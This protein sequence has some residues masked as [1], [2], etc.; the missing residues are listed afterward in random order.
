LLPF[1]QPGEVIE[2]IGIKK[3]EI[4]PQFVD[5]SSIFFSIEGNTKTTCPHPF[6]FEEN[7]GL[8]E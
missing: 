8:K 5:D 1:S 6:H 7:N 2:A 3:L 4:S